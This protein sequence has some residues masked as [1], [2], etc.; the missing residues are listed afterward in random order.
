MH[1]S[2]AEACTSA[3]IEQLVASLREL[4]ARINRVELARAGRLVELAAERA[5]RRS[6]R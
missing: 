1:P 6:R 5:S 3:S 2:N 4:D